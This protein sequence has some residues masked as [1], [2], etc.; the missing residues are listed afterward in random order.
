M[1]SSKYLKFHFLFPFFFF[2]IYLFYELITKDVLLADDLGMAYQ[3]LKNPKHFGDFLSSAMAEPNMTSRP[4]SAF[5]SAIFVFLI[6]YNPTFYY[7]PYLFFLISIII[8]YFTINNL[9]KNNLISLLATGVYTTVPLGTSIEFAPIMIKSSLATI[10]FCL[11]VICYLR[12]SKYSFFI[13]SILFLFSFLSYEIFAP[14]IVIFLFLSKNSLKAL[15]FFCTSVLLI[16]LYKKVIEP[17]FFENHYKRETLPNILNFGRNLKILIFIIKMFIRDLPNGIYR[18][19]VASQF[20]S[21]R[22][23]SILILFNGAI[24]ISLF[25]IKSFSAYI[26]R[27]LLLIISLSFLTS[28]LIF[29]LST[30]TPT[31]FGY[32]NRNL[33]AVRFFFSILFVLAIILILQFAGASIKYYKFT[34]FTLFLFLSFTNL[35]IKNAWVYANDF[36][37]DLFNKV[38]KKLPSNTHLKKIYIS[39][40]IDAFLKCDPNF[41]LREQIFYY[42]WEAPLL[43]ER[44]GI[45]KN[46]E[47]NFHNG[48]DLSN[49]YL[50]LFNENKMLIYE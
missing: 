35:S 28:F 49:C 27:K 15:Y 46:I 48:E 47:T 22:D 41:I 23:W 5:F 25:Q 21:W 7:I 18:G 24:A 38:A 26:S 44:A 43:N 14:A 6:K 39:Y 33:G 40:D 37:K 45:K 30:Y 36:N 11:A 42:K 31:I 4:I 13:S 16:L 19:V 12:Y 10:F 29:F 34:F 3:G 50:Y 17:S 8:V 20:Y 9:L 2:V 1:R 32:D